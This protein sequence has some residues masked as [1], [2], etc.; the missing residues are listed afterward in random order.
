M[1]PCLFCLGSNCTICPLY[2]YSYSFC[3]WKGTQTHLRHLSLLHQ[4]ALPRTESWCEDFHSIHP[5]LSL[6]QQTGLKTLC[7][8]TLHHSNNWEHSKALMSKRTKTRLSLPV[9]HYTAWAVFL[10]YSPFLPCSLFSSRLCC[11]MLLTQGSH[12]WSL[13]EHDWVQQERTVKNQIPA[14]VCTGWEVAHCLKS[15]PSPMRQ[16]IPWRAGAHRGLPWA[17]HL[18]PSVTQNVTEVR[19]HVVWCQRR[20]LYFHQFSF[21]QDTGTFSCCHGAAFYVFGITKHSGQTVICLERVLRNTKKSSC[22]PCFSSFST[23]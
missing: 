14:W 17:S 7:P 5:F 12:C 6:E 20:L 16:V 11:L 23:S 22:L 9:W 1:K 18:C 13:Q 10:P 19:G 8:G 3:I 4:E 15:P 2:I 21:P